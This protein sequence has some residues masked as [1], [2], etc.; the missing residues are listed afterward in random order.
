MRLLMPLLIIPLL[1][2]TPLPHDVI[3]ALRNIRKALLVDSPIDASANIPQM[4]EY[5]PGRAELW[6]LTAHYALLGGETELAVT[7]YQRAAILNSLSTYGFIEL[8]DAA[9]LEGN[10]FTAVE[11]WES[12]VNKGGSSVELYSRLLGAHILLNDYDG[13]VNDLHSLTELDSSNPIYFY[14]L[15]IF[16][17]SKQPNSAIA[18]LLRAAELDPIYSDDVQSIKRAID[19]AR[20]FDN[21]AY[22]LL[23][24]GRALANLNQW[25][26]AARAFKESTLIRPDYAE[27][28]AFLGEAKQHL[29]EGEVHQ[30]DANI[31]LME[32][33]H[34]LEINPQSIA[35][36]MLIALYWQRQDRYDLALVYLHKAENI[37]PDTP[38]V[39]AEIGRTLA[40]MGDLNKAQY[41][42]ERAIELAPNGPHY[43]RLLADFSIQYKIQLRDT[44]L[45]AARQA[46]LLNPDDPASL[47]VMGEVFILLEDLS[48]AIRFLKKA[49]LLDS[50]YAPAHLHLGFAYLLQGSVDL[51]WKHTSLAA[52]HAEPDSTTAEQAQRM[53]DT[54]FP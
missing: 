27:A 18:Y 1:G 11:A 37:E 10:L 46:V 7:Y 20:M 15:G 53:I 21:P 52:T 29:N 39:Q 9:L 14:E 42:Y 33:E 49:I 3:S 4:L 45:P 5:F 32:I 25:D 50:N 51:A 31:G 48:S 22:T 41:Y 2:I 36:N 19:S 26:H 8:G 17:A 13:I 23:E 12:A 40:I 54:Y 35:A 28:W 47:D 6:E 34:A 44:G 30:K 16:I 24:T 38:A 43:W